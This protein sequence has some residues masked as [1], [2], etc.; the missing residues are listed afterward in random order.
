MTLVKFGDLMKHAEQEGYAVG[1]FESWNLESL[2]AVADA[3]EATRSP[4]L[5]GF[6]GIYLPHPARVRCDPISMYAALGLEVCRQI[7][8]PAAL[9]FNECPKLEQVLE[10]IDQ[11]Y[12]LVMFSDESLPLEE[13]T[14]RVRQVVE[15]A[16][17]IGVAVEGEALTLPGVG[18]DLLEMSEHISLTEVKTACDFVEQTDVD[19]FAVNIGQMHLHGR[20]QVQLDLVRLQ[21]L[22]AA[23]QVPLVLH[24]ASSIRPDHLARAVTCGIRKINVG[25]LLKQ[26][27]FE[28]LREACAEIRRGYNPYEVI[29]SGLEGDVLMAGRVALQKKVEELMEL[30]G[31]TGKA[32]SFL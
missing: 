7:T 25:S 20:Q 22:Y 16:H 31:S 28:S 5:L 24:G 26:A 29:G 30:F 14:A 21:E 8:V 27:N 32:E 13:Q 3:A 18:G 12:S 9:V 4:V 15:A 10:A 1:Y 23:L 19:A 6:S 17:Q 11:G 2:M